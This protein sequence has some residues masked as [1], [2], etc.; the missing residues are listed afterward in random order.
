VSA[1]AE[2]I[3]S[4][5]AW[6]ATRVAGV[7]LIVIIAAIALAFWPSFEP[8]ATSDPPGTG[9][10]HAV[11]APPAPIVVNGRPCPQCLP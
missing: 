3:R 6:N 4:G 11:V 8:N 5:I 7:L 2:T 1:S 10:A 9:P